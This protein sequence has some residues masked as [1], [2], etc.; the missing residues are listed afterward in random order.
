M[1]SIT[2]VPL[3]PITKGSLSKLWLGV[4]IAALAGIGLAAVG[5]AQFGSTD[6]GL[7]YQVLDKGA[8]PS[9]SRDDFA[10]VGYKGTLSDGTVFDENA[11]APMEV[12]NVVPGFAEALTLMH[13]GGH[14]R[15]WIPAKLAYGENPPPGSGIPANAPLQFDIKLIEFKTRAE[16]MQLQQQ[17]QMQQMMQGGGGMPG[18]APV[19]PGAPEA[20]SAATPTP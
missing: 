5:S 9:P 1:S 20:P 12:A 10:L 16:V 3:R 6:S 4:G 18:G 17:M 7:K 13:K 14:M 19:A 2:A 11:R 8:G 15:V